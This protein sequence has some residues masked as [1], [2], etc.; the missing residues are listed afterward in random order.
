WAVPAVAV[1]PPPSTRS[2]ER[3]VRQLD[4]ELDHLQED[5][6]YER[7]KYPTGLGEE[8]EQASRAVA[9]F[10]HTLRRNEDPRHLM[11]EF[12]KM[13]RQIHEL[14]DQLNRSDDRWL[15]RQALR[16]RYPDEQLHFALRSIA[17]DSGPP[18]HE[19]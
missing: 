1:Q 6:H 17:R 18:A 5:L 14:V 7:G 10:H 12:E 11:R 15:C 4:N 2:A 16:I 8:V 3:W 9:H 13:D 19:M